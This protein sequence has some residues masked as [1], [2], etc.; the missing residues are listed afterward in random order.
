MKKIKT[1]I[2][3]LLLASFLMTT[4]IGCSKDADYLY[5]WLLEHG[6]LVD[7]TCLQYSETDKSGA[8]FMLCYD[9]NY[10]D[11]LRWQVQHS[12]TDSSGRTIITTLFLFSAGKEASSHISVY[13]LGE[14]DDYYRSL[15]YYHNP[16]IFTKNSPIEQ[17]ELSGSTVHVPDSEKALI[18]EILTLNTICENRAQKSLCLILDWLEN[19]FCPAAN[20]NMSDFGYDNY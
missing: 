6:T 5:D 2:A 7:G 16:A 4:C 11:K 19:T 9:T 8:K 10:V 14:Y 13:G 20:M 1:I 18:K 15:E 3:I 12:T 17:G